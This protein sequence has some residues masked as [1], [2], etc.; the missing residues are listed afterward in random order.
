[1]IEPEGVV[2]SRVGRRALVV[3]Q[4]VVLLEIEFTVTRH[5]VGVENALIQVILTR[6]GSR[7][8]GQANILRLSGDGIRHSN[9]L[10]LERCPGIAALGVKDEEKENDFF[11]C[12]WICATHGLSVDYLRCLR[13][14]REKQSSTRL[15][16]MLHSYLLL[17]HKVYQEKKENGKAYWIVPV[18]S[19]TVTLKGKNEKEKTQIQWKKSYRIRA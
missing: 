5:L 2:R 13:A 8:E 18:H 3:F 15:S 7:I 17:E 6:T 12:L 11:L 19:A 14:K 16:H 10:S 4:I 1:M 9:T